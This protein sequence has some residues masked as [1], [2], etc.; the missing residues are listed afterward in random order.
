MGDVDAAQAPAVVR[1]LAHPHGAPCA[2]DSDLFITQLHLQQPLLH[3]LLA[4][5][6]PHDGLPG[7]GQLRAQPLHLGLQ[8]A[9][10]GLLGLALLTDA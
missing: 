3:L 10:R 5:M 9:P 1:G 8:H 6:E 2:R 4:V 7:G